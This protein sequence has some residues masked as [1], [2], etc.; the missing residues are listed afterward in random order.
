MQLDF[1]RTFLLKLELMMDLFKTR[2]ERGPAPFHSYLMILDAFIWLP[3]QQRSMNVKARSPVAYTHRRPPHK[4][5][6]TVLYFILFLVCEWHY[7]L[8]NWPHVKGIQPRIRFK[9]VP[10]ANSLTSHYQSNSKELSE[11]I[12][13]QILL[14]KSSILEEIK[15]FFVTF[16]KIMQ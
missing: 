14:P 11:L 3:L 16:S 6:F 5:N 13:S 9:Q 7:F 10:A 15:T 8:Y 12:R 4:S 2:I 1:L